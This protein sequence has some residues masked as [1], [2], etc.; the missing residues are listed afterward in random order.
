MKCF[1][2]Y[3]RIISLII[4]AVF[5]SI[6][7]IAQDKVIIFENFEKYSDKDDIFNTWLLRSDNKKEA[8]SVYK[9]TEENKNKFLNAV[10]K[11]NSV[12]IA[13]KITWDIKSY[14]VLSWKWRMKS[15]PENANEEARGKNDS[16][17][18]IYILFQRSRIPFLSWEYQPVNVIKYVWSTTLPQGKIVRKEKTKLGSV[19]YEGYFFVIESGLGNAGKWMNEE[20]NVLNDYRK[21]FKEDP[22]YDPY[23]IAILSD[24]N[25]TKSTAIA[26]YDEIIIKNAE[27]CK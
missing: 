25:D 9:I 1:A 16:G 7:C 27:S 24:S 3:I 23:L 19:I 12:Q 5:Y 21:V 20:R 22:K 10:S 11:G 15:L 17:A 2:P 18:S 4:A 8:S 13:K 26:D 6:Y 14:P